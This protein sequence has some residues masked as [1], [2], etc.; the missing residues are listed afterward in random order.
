MLLCLSW[1]RLLQPN[2][3]SQ[4]SNRLALYNQAHF[5]CCFVS[6]SP[7][8]V[9]WKKRTNCVPPSPYRSQS[10][11]IALLSFRTA[12]CWMRLLSQWMALS[13][14]Q[15]PNSALCLSVPITI[16]YARRVHLQAISLWISPTEFQSEVSHWTLQNFKLCWV[17]NWLIQHLI[18]FQANWNNDAP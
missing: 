14:A 10:S 6:L 5:V 16:L 4:Y 8:G 17:F 15:H 3:F 13:W 18:A 12:S 9:L 1:T 11:V 2:G 7:I